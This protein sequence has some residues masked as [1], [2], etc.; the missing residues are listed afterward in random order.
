MPRRPH[1]LQHT[2][3]AIAAGRYPEVDGGWTRVPRWRQ[4][5]DA[6]LAV[7]G[8]AYLALPSPPD[9]PSDADLDALGCNGFGGAHDPRVA[10]AIAG[11]DGRCG[12]L[13]MLMAATAS[14]AEQRLVRRDDLASHPRVRSA[15]DVRDEVTS[16]GYH[17][18]AS[19]DVASIGRGVAGLTE[20]GIEAEHPGGG[21]RLA[22]DVLA[23]LPAGELVLA[24][25][26]PGNARSVLSLL[27]AGFRPIG[28]VQLITH[29][30][31]AD[32]P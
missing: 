5:V 31:G 29:P 21:S 8:R 18:K 19:G 11:T 16:W 28:S 2:I 20:I 22:A 26:S 12:V 17:D 7:T 23:T 9:G 10:L 15:A 14:G 4:G 6:V 25:V 30:A 27:R 32:A 24:A 1:P 13:D 3:S